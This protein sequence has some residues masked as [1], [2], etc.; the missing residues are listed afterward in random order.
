M[1]ALVW[2][3]D[4]E[5]LY[6]L[7]ATGR[8]PH[9]IS[10]ETLLRQGYERMPGDGPLTWTVPGAVDGWQQLLDRF[11]TLA[12]ADVLAPAIG[13]ARGGF[14]V[15]DIIA[16]QW[17]A[18]APALL[19]WP[20]SAAT[21]LPGG[22][23]PRAGEVFR[24]PR[25]A[26]TYEKLAEGGRDAFYRG[27]IARRIVAFSE[28]NGGYF[29]PADFEDHTS[30]W[31]EPVST[32]YRGY[33]VWEVPPNSSGVLAL[34]ILNLME[35]YDVAAL[36]H[37]SADAL[38]PVHRG[39]EAGVGRPRH[40]CGGRRRQQAADAAAH[41]EA[42]RRDAAQADRPRAGRHHRHPRPAVRAERHRLSHGGRQG[43]QRRLAHRERLRRLRL[44]GGAGRPRVRAPEPWRRVHAGGRPPQR[45][46]AAQALA[47]HQHARVRD[48]G[49]PARSCRSASWA[50]PCSRRGTGRC[51]RTSST[52]G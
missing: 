52:S 22:H 44:Q 24:N 18:A 6:A 25:L 35:G 34:M 9:A 21:Y 36:G 13:Y 49:W 31:V 42:V 23:A 48:A 45:A 39:E 43:P 16:G 20:D 51:C 7:N 11:G 1:F 8:A 38:H 33:D 40:L 46:G 5:R 32:N 26:A 19:E 12:L 27:D 3:A 29:T 28:A 2:H 30:V 17:N 47:A 4:T 15:S 37:N 14:A 50:A 41:L 10:R